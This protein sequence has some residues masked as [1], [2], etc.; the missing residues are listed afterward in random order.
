LC[1]INSKKCC[2]VL[3]SNRGRCKIGR[4]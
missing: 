3:Y 4:F 2:F 1:V